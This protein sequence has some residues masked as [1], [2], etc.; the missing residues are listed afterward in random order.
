MIQKYISIIFILIIVVSCDN[1]QRNE[2]ALAQVGNKHLYLSDIAYMFSNSISDE[3]SVKL[4]NEYV[5]KW[6]HKQLI[7]KKAEENLSSK[8]KDVSLELEDYRASLLTYRYEQAYVMQRMDTVVRQTELEAFYNDNTANFQL[9]S[10]I[11]KLIYIKVPNDSHALK[12]LRELYHSNTER[13]I[14]EL[15]SLCF[16]N[17]INYNTFNDEWVDISVLTKELPQNERNWE[18]EMINRKYI[19][20]EDQLFTYLIK[21]R[22]IK[23]KG[24]VA[25][26]EHVKDNIRNIILNLRKQN[27]IKKLENDIYNEALN[28]NELI[29]NITN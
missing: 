9:M 25:P 2:Q 26:F 20:A 5:N 12:R 13:S 18:N 27:M 1:N 29:I 8:E 11:I 3:D 21:V 28:H 23:V 15:E 22:D 24:T 10:P 4:L 17:G 6:A 14:I 7:L 16:E 19:D